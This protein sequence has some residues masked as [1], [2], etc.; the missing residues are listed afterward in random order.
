MVVMHQHWPQTE[1]SQEH[2]IQ[3]MLPN[4]SLRQGSTTETS[5]PEDAARAVIAEM[6]EFLDIWFER[7][8]TFDGQDG[9]GAVSRLLS[10]DRPVQDDT[11]LIKSWRPWMRVSGHAERFYRQRRRA[12]GR[13]STPGP[14]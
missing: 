1:G 10:N 4:N 12:N 6:T 14:E 11:R 2:F 7:V 8:T 5:M 9:R 13:R 3:K